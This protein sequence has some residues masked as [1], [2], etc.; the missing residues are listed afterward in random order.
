MQNAKLKMQKEGGNQ[1]DKNVFRLTFTFLILHFAF[2]SLSV[3]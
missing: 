2:F 1:F 3:R